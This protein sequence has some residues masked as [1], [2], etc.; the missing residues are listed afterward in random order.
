MK[1]TIDT[2]ED[3]HEEIKTAIQMLSSV[4][5]ANGAEFSNMPTHA[6]NEQPQPLLNEGIFGMFAGNNE[7][8]APFANPEIPNTEQTGTMFSENREEMIQA[9]EPVVVEGVK[10]QGND[11]DARVIVY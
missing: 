8:S 2:K 11:D 7:E 5:G 10:K 9:S 3:S 4:V 1:I 6:Q